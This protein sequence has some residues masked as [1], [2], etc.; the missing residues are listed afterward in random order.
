MHI[1]LATTFSK[2]NRIFLVGDSAH[3]FVPTGGFGLN[4]G[5]GD[6]VNLGWKLAAVIRQNTSPDLL[7]TYEQE[8]RP[9]CLHNLN[10]AQ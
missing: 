9:I 6:V 8:R 5:L 2:D 4:T 3:A 1:Q 10:I 7:A